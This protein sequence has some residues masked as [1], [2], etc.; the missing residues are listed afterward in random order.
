MAS[1]GHHGP[2]PRP[3]GLGLGL[4]L[5]WVGL[6]FR[7]ESLWWFVLFFGATTGASK[8]CVYVG[9]VRV[10]LQ[11]QETRYVCYHLMLRQP[12]R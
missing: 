4:G 6:G 3:W 7:V 11:F 10:P 5:G 1:F 12:S 9:V 2:G 8:I